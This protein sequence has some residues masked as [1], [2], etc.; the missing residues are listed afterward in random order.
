VL[1]TDSRV[2]SNFASFR[3]YRPANFQVAPSFRFPVSPLDESPGF[4]GF[5]I[6]QLCRRSIFE[7]PRV[8]YPS[9]VPS[10]KSPGFPGSSLFQ[11]RLSMRL[12]VSPTPTSS[13]FADGEF[14]GFPES[15]LP[16]RV[17]LWISRF[18]RISH[19]PRSRRSKLRVAPAFRSSGPAFA[20][21]PGLP[22]IFALPAVP[23]MDFRVSPN[24]TSSGFC[25]ICV[26]E[27]PR[28]LHLRLGR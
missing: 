22:R 6:F 24:F 3:F 9:A 14:P 11:F 2:A 28:I 4:P 10:G 13:G 17:G 23:T 21:I 27:R 15:S 25:R 8:S 5:C 20:R 19:P 1:A 7:F 12:R 16:R 18:P 26:F